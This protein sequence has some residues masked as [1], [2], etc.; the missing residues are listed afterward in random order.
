M[1][2]AT[3][4]LLLTQLLPACADLGDPGPPPG[5]GSDDTSG[6]ASAGEPTTSASQD[7]GSGSADASTTGPDGNESS[8]GDGPTTDTGPAEPACEGTCLAGSPAWHG[9]VAIRRSPIADAA[10]QCPAAYPD[11]VGEW[12]GD[13]VSNDLLCG[14]G[15]EPDEAECP[16]QVSLGY[17]GDGAGCMALESAHVL[18]QSCNSG[19]S[20]QNGRWFAAAPDVVGGSCTPTSVAIP[21]LAGFAT[22]WTLCAGEPAPGACADEESCA[23]AP[24][25][26]ED[27]L[28]IWV[29]GDEPCPLGD[30]VVREVIHADFDDQRDCAEC[31]CGDL[32]GSCGGTLRLYSENSCPAGGI[33]SAVLTAEVGE[34]VEYDP[35]SARLLEAL[36][37]NDDLACAPSEPMPI[38]EAVGTGPITV[39]CT[40]DA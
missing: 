37:P 9:P 39:C 10:P 7:T 4:I 23:S 6:T 13:L 21:T 1:K 29:D 20:G 33:A 32:S 38:G 35:Q 18:T 22:R 16:D 17:Y 25:P 40:D 30:F 5:Q 15:C 11:P 12:Y 36:T 8:S 24:Q 3:A 19:P 26:F 34:C 14:C 31:T 28:C 27:Q 2:R